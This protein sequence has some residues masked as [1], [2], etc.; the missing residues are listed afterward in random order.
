MYIGGENG[1]KPV[2]IYDYLVISAK[3]DQLTY[4]IC[5]LTLLIF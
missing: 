2:D 5:S 3:Q 1:R 4:Y